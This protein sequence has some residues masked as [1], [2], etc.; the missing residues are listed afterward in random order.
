MLN[1]FLDFAFGISSMKVL[2]LR[3][4]SFFP[5]AE[6]GITFFLNHLILCFSRS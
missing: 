1:S 5:S 3:L 2:V 4:G 6:A